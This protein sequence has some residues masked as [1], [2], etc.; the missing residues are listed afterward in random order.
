MER[1]GHFAQSLARSYQRRASLGSGLTLCTPS[2]ASSSASNVSASAMAASA[3]PALAARSDAGL[4]TLI[5]LL[6]ILHRRS[7]SAMSQWPIST[8]DIE[9]DLIGLQTIRSSRAKCRAVCERRAA[10]PNRAAKRIAAHPRVNTQLQVVC[11]D[12][13]KWTILT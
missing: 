4:L 6:L 13:R 3:S 1:R 12:E 7:G 2:R 5:K 8:L 10:R 9:A 11:C